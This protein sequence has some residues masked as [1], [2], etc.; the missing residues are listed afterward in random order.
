M[1]VAI[2]CGIAMLGGILY[3]IPATY[4]SL[5]AAFHLKPDIPVRRRLLM[6]YSAIYYPE[7]LDEIGLLYR[8]QA[9]KFQKGAF[10]LWTVMMALLLV[11]FFTR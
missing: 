2:G 9:F 8:S 3:A 4:Y 6:P 1:I 11:L 7:L 10:S 5:C